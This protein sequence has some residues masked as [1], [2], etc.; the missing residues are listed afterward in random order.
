MGNTPFAYV[1]MVFYG[2]A[3]VLRGYLF[4]RSAYFPKWL[5]A[6]LWLAGAGFIVKSVS[7]AALP[8]Y[9]SDLL[10]VPM[11]VA[12]IALALTLLF[13]RDYWLWNQEPEKDRLPI[14]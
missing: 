1:F 14:R 2:I 6:L 4:Y 10:L 12:M 8:Q 5:G 3:T 13:K 7:A 11:F 9:D